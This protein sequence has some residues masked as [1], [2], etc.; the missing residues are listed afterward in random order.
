MRTQILSEN[1][2]KYILS[3]VTLSSSD[4]MKKV[5]LMVSLGAIDS[6]MFIFL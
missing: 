3:F 4:M 6:T 1:I 2:K 5:H